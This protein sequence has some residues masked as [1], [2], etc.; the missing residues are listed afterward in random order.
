M[1]RETQKMSEN[2]S[3]EAAL[4]YALEGRVAR[5]IQRELEDLIARRPD[6]VIETITCELTSEGVDF[7]ITFHVNDPANA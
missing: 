5:Y 1:E 2:L 4:V 7:A 6:L 3:V